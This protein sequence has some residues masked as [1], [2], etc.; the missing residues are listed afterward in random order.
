MKTK[1]Y[2][3]FM[4]WYGIFENDHFRKQVVLL[5]GYVII[6]KLFTDEKL[7]L[8]SVLVLTKC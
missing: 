1:I 4:V 2:G 8:R 7:L 3:I 6:F 5:A